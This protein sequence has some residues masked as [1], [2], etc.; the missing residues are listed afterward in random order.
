MFFSKY[1]DDEIRSACRQ[2]LET[3]EIWLRTV[4]DRELKQKFSVD[5]LDAVYGPDRIIKR[6]MVDEIKK[7]KS[8]E[9]QRFPRIID[10]AFLDDLIIIIHR[11]KLW[12]LFEPYLKQSFPH[13]PNVSKETMEKL[14]IPRNHLSHANPISH[15]QAEQIICYS[16]D[17]IDSIK[18]HF[19][20]L[21]MDIQF[22]TPTITRYKDS[23]GNE[24]HFSQAE[25]YKNLRF[26]DDKKTFLRPGDTLEME[27]EVDSSFEEDDYDVIW[28]IGGGKFIANKKCTLLI[29]IYHVN[30]LKSFICRIKSKEEWHKLGDIDDALIVDFTVLPPLQ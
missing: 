25:T 8:N 4:V 23:F 29:E 18:A 9:P 15:R 28:E 12:P 5:Y 1:T 22:N 14:I 21:N 10:A 17:I 16:H 11:Q 30:Q 27:V 3:L 7:R 20:L 13:G 19:I 6:E 2:T 24:Y 26:H